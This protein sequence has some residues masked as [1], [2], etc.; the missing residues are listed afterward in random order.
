MGVSPD[1]RGGRTPALI[2]PVL[3]LLVLVLGIVGVVQAEVTVYHQT[4]FG[5]SQHQHQQ[6]Q[7]GS[8]PIQGN[9]SLTSSSIGAVYTGAPAY[10]PMVLQAPPVPSLTA[11]TASGG[12][13][14]QLASSSVGVPLLSVPVGAGSSDASSSFW[15]FSIEFSVIEQVCKWVLR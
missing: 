12:Y 11:G 13:A 8:P 1:R 5:V 14:I 3:L 6:Q 15:G 9:S 10:D 2:S 7:H 4:P